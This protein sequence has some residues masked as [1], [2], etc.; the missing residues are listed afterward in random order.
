MS[1]SPKKNSTKLLFTVAVCI[2]PNTMIGAATSPSENA[3]LVD[4]KLYSGFADLEASCRAI[5]PLASMPAVK[6][7]AVQK[8]RVVS[9]MLWLKM[10]LLPKKASERL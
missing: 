3:S 7:S 10:W 1:H 9:K 2:S 6:V 5:L 8:A 4:V